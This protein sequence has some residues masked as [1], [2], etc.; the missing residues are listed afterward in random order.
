MYS[1]YCTT[2]YIHNNNG[3]G[4]NGDGDGGLGIHFQLPGLLQLSAVQ[5]LSMS[6][7]NGRRQSNHMESSA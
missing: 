4:V 2:L 1:F 3:G 7:V 6:V 5:F